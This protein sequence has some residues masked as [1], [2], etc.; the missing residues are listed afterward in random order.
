MRVQHGGI[1]HS[2]NLYLFYKMTLAGG[3][4][5][6]LLVYQF[7][8]VKICGFLFTE[9]YFLNWGDKVSGKGDIRYFNYAVAFVDVL[10][11]REVFKTLNKLTNI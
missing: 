5:V 10:G 4:Q 3:K 7:D 9:K 2:C 11:Q 1:V 6:F 8:G